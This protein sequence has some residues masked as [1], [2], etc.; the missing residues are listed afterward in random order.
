MS[1]NDTRIETF[2]PECGYVGPFDI[3][4]RGSTLRVMGEEVDYTEVTAFCPMCNAENGDSRLVGES[5][6][7]A[8]DVYRSRHGIMS[9]ED[10][11]AL[12]SAYGMS[13]RQFSRFLGFGEQT[14]ARYERGSIPDRVHANAINEA[15][16]PD[17]ALRLLAANRDQMDDDS[18]SHAQAFASK[19]GKSSMM[20]TWASVMEGGKDLAIRGFRGFDEARVGAIVYE[21]ASHCRDLY[22]TKFQKAMFF[23]DSLSF[24]RTSVSMSGLSYAHA[25][26]GPVIDGKDT[27]RAVLAQGGAVSFD[28]SELGD[29]LV[30]RTRPNVVLS[31]QEVAL[32]AEVAA[33]VNTFGTCKEISD[34]SHSLSAW[35]NTSDGMAIPYVG[36]ADEVASAVEERLA[37]SR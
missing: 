18:I 24:S 16:T 32:I 20:P 13:T 26:Y 12:R 22:W 14:E 7:R 30:P 34:F 21:L 3:V 6:R 33:V 4:E 15:S 2:C 28:E 35:A 23:L 27:L 29:V 36:N 17:G 37:A 5:Q 10:L 8:Y 25:T 31:E 11:R 19:G 1:P 9:P